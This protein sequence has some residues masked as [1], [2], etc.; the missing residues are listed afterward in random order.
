MLQVL[1]MEIERF[2]VPEVLFN[3]SDIGL[4]M[5]GIAEATWQSL[6]SLGPVEAQLCGANIVLTGGNTMFPQFQTRFYEEIRKFFPHDI[7]VQV[8]TF[9]CH[10]ALQFYSMSIL[11]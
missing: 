6:Q 1:A 10:D 7:N 11:Y 9:A 8:S 5:A 4:D 3:P 2:A